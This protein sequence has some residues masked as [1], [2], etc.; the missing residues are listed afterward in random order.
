MVNE[1]Q[2]HNP[3]GWVGDGPGPDIC[4]LAASDLPKREWLVL[5]E[6]L[7]QVYGPG[8]CKVA[9]VSPRELMEHSGLADKNVYWAL[10][11]LAT[12]IIRKHK[13]GGYTFKEGLP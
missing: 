8:S 9:Y 4:A 1:W 13:R 11:G 3:G 2:I 7:L 6:I 5:S 12:G 10:K